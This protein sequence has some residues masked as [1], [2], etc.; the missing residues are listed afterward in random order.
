MQFAAFLTAVKTVTNME[1]NAG[2]HAYCK[3][4]CN[5]FFQRKFPYEEVIKFVS[6]VYVNYLH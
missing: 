3:I 2:K 6:Q 4:F 1:K 5:F